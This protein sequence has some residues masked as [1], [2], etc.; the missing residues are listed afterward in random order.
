MILGI[1]STFDNVSSWRFVDAAY[2]FPNPANPWETPFPEVI[3]INNL[4]T[5]VSIGNDFIA[6]KIGDVNGDAQ[7]EL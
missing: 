2:V 6:I 4:G 5:A 1:E 7:T 3:N